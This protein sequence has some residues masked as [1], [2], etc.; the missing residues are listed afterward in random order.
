MAPICCCFDQTAVWH[1]DAARGPST[2]SLDYL[3]GAREH[4]L[5]HFEAER[6][7]GLEVEHQLVLGRR[8]YRQVAR[9]LAL[10]DAIYI[11]RRAPELVDEIGP[12]GDH[13]AGGG[14]AAFKIDR[15]Q[16]VTGR[17]RNDQIAVKRSRPA[18]RHDQTSVR[19]AHEGRKGA[20]SLICVAHVDWV[21]FHVERRRQGPDDAELADSGGVRGISKDCHSR[22]TRRDLLQQFQPFSAQAVFV[23]HEAGSVAARPR[24]AVDEAC[25][26]RIADNWE[27]DRHGAGCQQQW[28]HGRGAKSKDDVR[29]E[30]DQFRRVSANVGDTGC[31]PASVDAHVTAD[32]PP[33]L[34]ESLQERPD[35]SLKFRIVRGCG[36]EHANTPRSLGLLRARRQRPRGCRTAEQRDELTAG[37]HSIT[38]SA[39][40]S[41]EGGSSRPSAFAVLRLI[42]SSYLVGACTGRSAGFSPLRMRST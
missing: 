41:T 34:L 21:Y 20:L 26:D 33:Q 11:P 9:L 14:E 19:R 35:A 15:G 7:G 30:R 36:Q 8:L 38:S 12:I 37:A 42:T 17:Q 18:P 28:A 29:R 3:V 22:Y 39:R 25:T 2:P 31:G 32:C 10:E 6:L 27:H 13:A 23:R 40:A 24:Q 16:F 4:R 5:R 1:S